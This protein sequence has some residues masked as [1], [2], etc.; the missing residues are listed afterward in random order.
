MEGRKPAEGK[1]GLRPQAEESARWAL[2]GWIRDLEE[3]EVDALMRCVAGGAGDGDAATAGDLMLECAARYCP[4][5]PHAS[6]PAPEGR[7]CPGFC[8]A[9]PAGQGSWGW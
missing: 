2:A 5:Q 9:L 3:R 6:E 4:A 7:R 8:A 1:R